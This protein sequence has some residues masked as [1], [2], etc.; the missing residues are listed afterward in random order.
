MTAAAL[1]SMRSTVYMEVTA[2]LLQQITCKVGAGLLTSSLPCT[3]I[4]IH[5]AAHV[6]P[7]LL[8]CETGIKDPLTPSAVRYS[9]QSDLPG[10]A[11]ISCAQPRVAAPPAATPLST[12]A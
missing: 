9:E 5:M 1:S 8:P 10:A 12:P 3:V 2:F 7:K 11:C 4:R 6:K